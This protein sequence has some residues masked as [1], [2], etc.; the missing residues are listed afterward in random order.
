MTEGNLKIVV[1]GLSITSSWGNGHAT[2][3]R[4]LI[5]EL[6]RNGHDVTFLERD[7]PW[8]ASNRD[9][10]DFSY[11]KTILYQNIDELKAAHSETIRNADLVVVGSYV[12]EGVDVG[13]YVTQT[14]EGITA[15]YDIDTPVT[16]AKIKKEDYEYL[17]P[18]LIPLYNMYLSFT[19]GPTLTYLEEHYGSPMARPFYCSF[20]PELYYPEAHEKQWDLGYLGTYSDDRQPPLKAL[21]L[22]AAEKMPGGKFVV[23]GPQYPGDI[24]WAGNVARIEHLPPSE[25][26][27]FYNSQRFAMNITRAD[28]IRAGYSPS[29]RLFEAAACNTPII[30]DYWEG[31]DTIFEHGKEILISH[32]AEDTVGFLTNITESERQAI[33]ENARRK[34]LEFHTAAHRATEL[35]GYYAEAMRMREASTAAI[36]PDTY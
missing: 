21:M 1:L 12:P 28:M 22:D 3:F 5:R 6:H 33:A 30:S 27:K 36:R 2:T 24:Q 25:H 35:E 18:N 17:H 14:A 32:S 16:L 10:K 34:V 7:V 26:R 13:R 29:V 19:G 9:L 31:L 8:Y 15:F 11:C 20:D 4:G 23:A